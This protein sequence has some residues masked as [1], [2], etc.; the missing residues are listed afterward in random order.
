MVR[1]LAYENDIPKRR[2]LAELSRQ[3]ALTRKVNHKDTKDTMK[4]EEW[5]VESGQ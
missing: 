1:Q 5:S 4:D 3:P 2:L